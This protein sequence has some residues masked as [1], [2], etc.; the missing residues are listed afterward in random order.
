MD[1]IEFEE[2]FLLERGFQV[3]VVLVGPG[4]KPAEHP[5]L[6]LLYDIVAGEPPMLADR[7]ST[8]TGC[9]LLGTRLPSNGQQRVGGA[10]SLRGR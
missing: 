2:F 9:G 1:R 8:F 7:G 6:H 5:F 3:S 10:A 4:V